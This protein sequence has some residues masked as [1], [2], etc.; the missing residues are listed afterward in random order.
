M[1]R[2]EEGTRAAGSEGRE[3]RYPHQLP[4]CPLPAPTASSSPKALSR[5]PIPAST[6]PEE[7]L[8]TGQESSSCT[9]HRAP[10]SPHSRAR[11]TCPPGSVPPLGPRPAA[12]AGSGQPA[13]NPAVLLLARAPRPSLPPSAVRPARA[14]SL[15]SSAAALYPGSRSPLPA[16]PGLPALKAQAPFVWAPLPLLRSGARRPTP[17]ARRRVG[18]GETKE[19]APSLRAPP[20]LLRQLPPPVLGRQAATVLGSRPW[21]GRRG[22]RTGGGGKVQPAPGSLQPRASAFSSHP[23]PRGLAALL[24]NP[25]SRSDCPLPLAQAHPRAAIAP[26]H[27]PRASAS[28][29]TG[30]PGAESA[31]RAH[32]SP[33]PSSP[34]PPVPALPAV[35]LLPPSGTQFNN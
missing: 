32:F 27:S 26:C 9:E 30:T 16:A 23:H 22:R 20:P 19:G 34:H 29:L 18:V 24:Q 3:P 13:G 21:T 1:L 14:P 2:A 17:L 6:P 10:A 33:F 8:G 5:F 7:T 25:P 35:A 4:H 12:P 31:S 15:L 28:F 11:L